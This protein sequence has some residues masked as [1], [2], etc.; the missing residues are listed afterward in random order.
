[1]IGPYPVNAERG[2]AMYASD[3]ISGCLEQYCE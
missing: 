3:D 1:M 2:G